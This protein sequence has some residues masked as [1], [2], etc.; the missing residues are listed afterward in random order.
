MGEIGEKEA[1]VCKGPKVQSGQ[2]QCE[3]GV[4]GV[5]LQGY[6]GSGGTWSEG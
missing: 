4:T 3:G 1:S 5:T 2:A 6:E